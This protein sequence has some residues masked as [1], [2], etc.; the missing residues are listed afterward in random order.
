MENN[1][2]TLTIDGK[3]ITVKKGSTVLDAARKADIDIPTLCFLKDINEVG[4]CRMCLVEIEG[5]RGYAASCVQPAE[6]GMVVCTNSPALLDTKKTI[7]E[8]ILSAHEK[9]CLTCVRNQN[10][11]LQKLAKKFGIEDIPFEGALPEKCLDTSSACIVRNTAKCIL[12]KR[13][14]SVCKKVQGVSAISTM[15]RGFKSKVGVALDMP[16]VKSTCVGCGQCVIHCPVAAL[17]EKTNVS[18]LSSKLL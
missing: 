5:A 6:E 12:C 13:C 18:E 3:K 11:E 16:L 9:N 4:A 14:V 8:L 2:I 15:N 10:C 7:L 1:N 17:S